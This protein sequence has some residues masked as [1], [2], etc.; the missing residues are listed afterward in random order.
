MPMTQ[1][2]SDYF[3]KPVAEVDPDIAEVLKKEAVRQ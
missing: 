2:S 1:L 3:T